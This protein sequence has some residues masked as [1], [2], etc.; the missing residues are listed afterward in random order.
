M[1]NGKRAAKDEKIEKL[2]VAY[3][4]AMFDCGEFDTGEKE[5][6]EEEY[7]KLV[8]QAYKIKSELLDAIGQ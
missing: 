5:G 8:I 2:L 7:A 4:D 1:M 6:W 3:G